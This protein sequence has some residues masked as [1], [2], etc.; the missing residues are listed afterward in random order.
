MPHN[1]SIRKILRDGVEMMRAQTSIEFMLI[2]SAVS[3]LSLS[4][5]SLYT[6]G[7]SLEHST[8]SSENFSYVTTQIV[9]IN[10]SAD[11]P[12]FSFA[13]PLNSS[14]GKEEVAQALGYGCGSGSL[15]FSLSSSAILFNTTSMRGNFSGMYLSEIRFMPTRAGID[16][17]SINYSIRCAGTKRNG[18]YYSYTDALPAAYAYSDSQYS[19]TIS[20]ISESVVYNESTSENVS[21]FNEWD[22]CTQI[23]FWGNP[24]GINSQC[25]TYN[26]WEYNIFSAGCYTGGGSQTETF[27]ITPK[28]TGFQEVGTNTANAPRYSYSFTINLTTPNGEMFSTV[29]SSSSRDFVYSANE[30]VGTASIQ[31]VSYTGTAE[32]PLLWHSGSMLNVDP[33][34]YVEYSRAMTNAKYLL[35][36]YNKTDISS[37]EQSAIQQAIA[38]YENASSVMIRTA[39]PANDSCRMSY[40]SILCTP[41]VRFT[42]VILISLNDSNGVDSTVYYNGSKIEIT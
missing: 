1:N 23:G 12:S 19:A 25:G 2:L 35:W 36:Y 27:C 13:M 20:N 6:K 7:I 32:G 21:Q 26:A 18:T 29:I 3:I 8:L 42:F 24:Y 14:V 22:H 30:I 28:N 10:D 37:P 38:A 41:R 39:D 17:A 4:A 11:A 5:I 33:N 9:P 31:N 34:S 16:Y 40:D 15:N